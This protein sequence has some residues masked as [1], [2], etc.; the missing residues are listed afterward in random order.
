MCEKAAKKHLAE[1]KQEEKELLAQ[2]LLAI[3]LYAQSFC[4][5]QASLELSA[6]H[7]H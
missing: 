5:H 6:A 3:P 7:L 2:A 1:R 4:P